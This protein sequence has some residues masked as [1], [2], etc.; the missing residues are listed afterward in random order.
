[1]TDQPSIT[2]HE[3]AS[4]GDGNAF[5]QLADMHYQRGESG[6]EPKIIAY[7]RAVD[8]A[9]FAA[10]IVGE[11]LHWITFLYLLD[12]HATALRDAGLTVLADQA[13]GE[14]VALAEYMGEDG[15]EEI[16]SMIVTA[17][18]SLSPEVL[19]IAQGLRATVKE[20]AEC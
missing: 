20:T 8:C 2:A 1:M 7:A 4:R 11:R 14:A 18:D 12:C 3:A 13:L 16:G 10:M 19:A 9:R 5:A 15:D 17:A 6:A